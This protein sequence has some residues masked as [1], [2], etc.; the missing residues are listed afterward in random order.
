ML[1]FSG[2]KILPRYS[3]VVYTSLNEQPA[4]RRRYIFLLLKIL[5]VLGLIAIAIAFSLSLHV[6]RLGPPKQLIAEIPT[7]PKEFRT[8]GLVFYGRRS[9]VEVLDCYLKQ[10]EPWSDEVSQQNL[11]ENGGLLDEVI[12]LART[13]DVDDLAWLDQLVTTSDGYTRHNLTENNENASKVSYGGT[14]DIVERGTLYVKFDDD[15]MYIAP[16]AISSLIA[17]KIAHP[18]H[19]VTSA[20][21]VNSPRLTWLHYHMDLIRPYLPELSPPLTPFSSSSWRASELPPWDGPPT[22]SLAKRPDP[23][24]E[25]HRWLPL[26][27]NYGLQG[28]PIELV[29]YHKTTEG[30]MNW[31]LAA[32]VHYS[33]LEHL[34]QGEEGLQKYKFDSL[35]DYMGERLSINL[36]A[37]W[38]DDVVDNRPF[39]DD[40]EEYLTRTLVARTGRREYQLV[41][42]LLY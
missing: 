8:V 7:L 42:V 5:V 29:E 37:I 24:F 14:W 15:I 33:F 38:G 4:K 36:I 16:N 2:E 26:G 30:I 25:H 40:D 27:P 22:F 35:W 17:T 1:F 19:I 23:P 32:Q 11:K 12:F 34:E 13:D 9:R 18:E 31:A 6:P 28:T 39:P 3:N 10:K 21:I 41:V 20:N